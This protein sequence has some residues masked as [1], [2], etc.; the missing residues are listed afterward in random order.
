VRHQAVAT[1]QAAAGFALH[2]AMEYLGNRKEKKGFVLRFAMAYL[3]INISALLFFC[4]LAKITCASSGELV[5]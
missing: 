2:F 1:V 3:G 5:T 4:L